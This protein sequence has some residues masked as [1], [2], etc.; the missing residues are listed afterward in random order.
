MSHT[1]VVPSANPVIAAAGT[2]EGGGALSRAGRMRRWTEMGLLFVLAPLAMRWIV[3]DGKIPMFAALL[4]VLVVALFLLLADPTFRLRTELTR[5]I[6]WRNGIS[7]GSASRALAWYP[8]GACA[9]SPGR[10]GRP[11]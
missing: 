4:P 3:H 1:I 7:R 11:R 9:S 10:S 8:P 6:G 5:R 2:R